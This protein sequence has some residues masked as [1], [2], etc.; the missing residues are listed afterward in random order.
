MR[1]MLLAALAGAGTLALEVLAM[2]WLAPGFGTGIDVTLILIAV[3]LGGGALGAWVGGLVAARPGA[4][5][6]A[7]AA[8]AVAML[9]S[10]LGAPPFVDALVQLPLFAGA[11]LAAA[12]IVGPTATALGAVVP[13]LVA[14]LRAREAGARVVGRLIAAA[15]GGSLVGVLGAA[16][17]A[18]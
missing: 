16:L 11:L 17:F 15:T 1:A 14:R 8:A 2:R 7:F 5:L 3:T 13:F 12:G 18:T 6:V 9:A 4:L 10:A